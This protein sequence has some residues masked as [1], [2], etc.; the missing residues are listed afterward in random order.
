MSQSS[1]DINGPREYSNTLGDDDD[2]DDG[3]GCCSCRD[4]HRPDSEVRTENHV[5]TYKAGLPRRRAS[6]HN[7]TIRQ[8]GCTPLP[9]SK[10]LRHSR[11]MFYIMLSMTKADISQPS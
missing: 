3:E 2:V 4:F 9:Y 10:F 8:V 7:S 1:S 11:A 6:L 5:T